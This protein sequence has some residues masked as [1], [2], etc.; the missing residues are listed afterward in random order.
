LTGDLTKQEQKVL[1]ALLKKLL[2]G[3]EPRSSAGEE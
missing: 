3:L 2:A 1:A